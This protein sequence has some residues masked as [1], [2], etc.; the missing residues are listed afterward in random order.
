M[1]KNAD[2]HA[3]LAEELARYW[4]TF[5][6]AEVLLLQAGLKDPP[7]ESL[8]ENHFWPMLLAELHRRGQTVQL[9]ALIREAA[10]QVPRSDVLKNWMEVSMIQLAKP[11]VLFLKV[12]SSHHSP[13]DCGSEYNALLEQ[14]KLAGF[15]HRVSV[16]PE[17]LNDL[18]ALTRYIKASTPNL[19]HF[20]CHGSKG[21]PAM[22]TQAG[23][24]VKFPAIATILKLLFQGKDLQGVLFMGCE[25]H[26]AAEEVGNFAPFAVGFSDAV[27]STAA[28]TFSKCFYEAL[29]DSKNPRDAFALAVSFASVE[30]P[31]LPGIA[32]F[33]P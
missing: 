11:R 16:H 12:E 8:G 7:A 28:T 27:K 15:E 32:V 3:Q 25:T 29:A 20:C 13:I 21:Y 30:Q 2:P 33:C 10:R 24:L 14:L 9:E 18:S 22:R 17:H 1:S 19:L 6:Q 5:T 31:N 4:T 26:K 23:G